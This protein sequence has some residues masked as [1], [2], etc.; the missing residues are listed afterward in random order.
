MKRRDG[1]DPHTGDANVISLE[2]VGRGRRSIFAVL[3]CPKQEREILWLRDPALPSPIDVHAVVVVADVLSALP[4]Y[5]QQ[6]YTLAIAPF[7]IS[8]GKGAVVQDASGTRIYLL[9]RARNLGEPGPTEA[10]VPAHRR[11]RISSTLAS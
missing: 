9:E 11:M 7:T 1:F 4:I 5:I 3:L 6:N 2:S 8:V 10:E